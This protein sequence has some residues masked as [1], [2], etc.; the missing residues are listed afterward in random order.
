[1]L[2]KYDEIFDPNYIGLSVV[3]SFLDMRKDLNF[4]KGLLGK[5]RITFDHFQ[6]HFLLMLMVEYFED[7][8]VRTLTNQGQD[9]VAIGNVVIFNKFIFLS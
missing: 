2:P 8:A 3:I 1:M 4:D 9:L 6:C 7:L 5:L